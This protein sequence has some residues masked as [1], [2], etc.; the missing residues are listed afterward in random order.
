M[1][2]GKLSSLQTLDLSD[3]ELEGAIPAELG[4]LSQLRTLD[5]SGNLF[6]TTE[7]LTG[8][9]ICNGGLYGI[10]PTELSNL[11]ALEMLSLQDNLSLCW[12][13]TA[14]RQWALTLPVYSGATDCSYL[15]LTQG[16]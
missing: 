11:S 8:E 13:T 10:I 3:N 2:L 9:T 7:Y 15:P 16:E 4:D 1:S 5:L 6:C 14:A 12:E